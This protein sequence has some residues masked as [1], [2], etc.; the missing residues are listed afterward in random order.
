MPSFIKG[1]RSLR[2]RRHL[3]HRSLGAARRTLRLRSRRPRA[4]CPG[5]RLSPQHGPV[6]QLASVTPALWPRITVNIIFE[7]KYFFYCC[8][9][10]TITHSIYRDTIAQSKHSIR[11]SPFIDFDVCLAI[12][13]FRLHH[14]QQTA[15]ALESAAAYSSYPTMAGE[16]NKYLPFLWLADISLRLAHIVHRDHLIYDQRARSRF[17]MTIMTSKYF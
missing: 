4:R 6:R 17:E 8:C 2:V 9:C 3:F 15:H 1:L 7:L 16:Q 13:I 5:A 11:H 14:D 10:A 12:A